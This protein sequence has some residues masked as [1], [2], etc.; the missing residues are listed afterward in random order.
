MGF[1]ERLRQEQGA[2]ALREQQLKAQQ[3]AQERERLQRQAAENERRA[4]RKE[5]AERFRE[6]S[7]VGNVVTE[8]SNFLATPT[9]PVIRVSTYD[10]MYSE[11]T[12]FIGRGS[13]S[14]PTS[15]GSLPVS[16]KD[17]DSVFDIVQWDAELNGHSKSKVLGSYSHYSTKY[18]AVESCPDG[19]IYLHGGWGG[20]TTIRATQWRTSDKE[21][22]FDKAL[23]RAYKNP[24]IHRYKLWNK[25]IDSGFG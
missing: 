21:Q 11:Y 2:S 6:E 19:V 15:A 24:G 4:K 12:E 23:E 18:I 13:S 14:G 16:Q 3:E 25:P 9:I 7:K 10:G 5:Q 1:I 8:L 22:I 20:S 17:Q